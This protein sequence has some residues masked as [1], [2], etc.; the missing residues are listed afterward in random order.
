MILKI[1]TWRS[2]FVW[3]KDRACY[4]HSASC[5]C[6]AAHTFALLEGRTTVFDSDNN[7]E[8]KWWWSEGKI[9]MFAGWIAGNCDGI[10]STSKCFNPFVPVLASQTSCI[11]IFPTFRNM[12][13]L[14][15]LVDA[16]YS[17]FH[18][19]YSRKARRIQPVQSTNS[20]F[21]SWWLSSCM[22]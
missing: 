9:V 12:A 13:R 1:N 5:L 11:K 15:W 4:V 22:F 6:A 2:F 7:K 21:K 19:F 20:H 8:L 10:A 3:F 14:L 16:F 17:L 18:F